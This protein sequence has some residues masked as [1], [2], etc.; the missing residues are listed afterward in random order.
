MV[1]NI[2]I[3]LLV[4]STAVLL[5]IYIQ[6]NLQIHR[7]QQKQEVAVKIQ[8]AVPVDKKTPPQ[9]ALADNERT[10]YQKRIQ[11]L[12]TLL[13]SA[14]AARKTPAEKSPMEGFAEM[15]NSP[16]MKEMMHAQQKVLLELTHVS[17]FKTL[18]L[19]PEKLEALKDLLSEKN[20]VLVDSSLEMM[21]GALSEEGQK[22]FKSAKEMTVEF[23]DSIRSLLGEEDYMVYQEHEETKVERMQLAFFKQLLSPEDHLDEEQELSLIDAM[24]EER[25]STLFTTG[26]DDQDSYDPSK[27][28][29][30]AINQ[31]IEELSRSQEKYIARAKEILTES[32]MVKFKNFLDQ[33]RNMQE[34]GMKMAAKMFPLAAGK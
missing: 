33:Q 29:E 23:E 9:S 21:G 19:S 20:M 26:L 7:L 8:P 11:R 2:I 32:Q 27:L 25:E 16:E 5:F 13:D 10:Q 24:H 12:E 14:R 15:F 4:V 31:H 18:Q 6:Q 17:L 3:F 28:T 30:E 34:M 1:K 22:N